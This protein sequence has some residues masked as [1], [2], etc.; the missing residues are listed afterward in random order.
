[1]KTL[2]TAY[3][4]HIGFLGE[5]E[6]MP[7]HGKRK[8]LEWDT[9]TTSNWTRRVMELRLKLGEL[10]QQ[11]QRYSALLKQHAEF[12][13]YAGRVATLDSEIECVE[14][15]LNHIEANEPVEHPVCRTNEEINED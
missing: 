9:G 14:R 10:R 5:H 3:P 1:M 8:P 7:K 6:R 4:D 13:T 11:R 2:A 12:V 15:E